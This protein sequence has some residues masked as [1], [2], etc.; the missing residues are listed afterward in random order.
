MHCD[1]VLTVSASKRLIAKGFVTLPCVQEVLGKGMLAVAKGS[2]NAYL[3]EELLGKPIDKCQYMTGH[4]LPPDS[5][6]R[7][8]IGGTMADLV[9]RDGYPVEG[10][11][12]TEAVSQM[13]PGDI[14]CK[15]ANALNYE[16][17]QAALL[18]GHPTTGGTVGSALGPAY[19]RQV[20]WFI[21]VGLEKNVPVDLAEM[22][23][24]VSYNAGSS[25]PTPRLWPLAGEI[26]TEIEAIAA[27]FGVEAVP[28]AAGGLAGAEG[29]VRLALFGQAEQLDAAGEFLDAIRAEPPF[30]GT[31]TI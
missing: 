23:R 19:S 18:I 8:H 17:K 30:I 31:V 26:F 27:L 1:V 29:S 12:A 22:A 24:R 2:T 10:V 3:V 9:L 20:R 11:S 13:S 21:P 25:R 15:G 6:A 4:V 5:P 16:R 7:G 28:M 14:F